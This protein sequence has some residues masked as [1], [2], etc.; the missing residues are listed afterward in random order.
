MAQNITQKTEKTPLKY[1]F[2]FEKLIRDD[3]VAAMTVSGI[4]VH[5]RT[6]VGEEYACAL[7]KKL[8]EEV[9]EVAAASDPQ[10][11][12]EELADVFEVI[13]AIAGAHGFDL[14]A[15]A[16]KA[17]EKRAAKGGFSGGT[18]VE[19]IEMPANHP[20]AAYYLSR[21]VDYPVVGL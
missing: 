9:N 18:Y 6:I 15:I 3:L 1:R 17:Q 2:S 16:N 4:V 7:V 14:Q 13:T 21:S 5:N 8:H 20:R 12:I 19:W 11:I 10:E